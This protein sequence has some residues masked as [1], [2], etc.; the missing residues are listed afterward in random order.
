MSNLKKVLALALAFAMIMT[1]MVGAIPAYSDNDD[2]ATTGGDTALLDSAVTTLNDL[3]IMVGTKTDDGTYFN[4]TGTL[5]RAELSRLAYAVTHNGAVIASTWNAKNVT[6]FADISN[7]WAKGYI[8]YGYIMGYLSGKSTTKFDPNGIVTGYELGSVLVRLV[9]GYAASDIA[10]W[11]YDVEKLGR[12][13]GANLYSLGNNVEVDLATP[14][15]RQDAAVL[16]FN[17]MN[18]KTVTYLTTVNSYVASTETFL[19]Q[20]YSNSVGVTAQVIAVGT[21][22][23]NGTDGYITADYTYTANNATQHKY[24]KLPSAKATQAAI[25]ADPSILTLLGTE[26]KVNSTTDTSTVSGATIATSLT[27]TGKY[28]T[29]AVAKKNVNATINYAGNANK[30]YISFNGVDASG[31]AKVYSGT[32]EGAS[33][34]DIEY[35]SGF[36]AGAAATVDT[37][38][39]A[40]TAFK[41]NSNDLV[42]FKLEG[43]TIKAVVGAFSSKFAKVTS[44]AS[45]GKTVKFDDLSTAYVNSGATVKVGDYVLYVDLAQTTVVS[46]TVNNVYVTK[47]IAP[48]KYALTSYKSGAYYA[49]DFKLVGASNTNPSFAGLALGSSYMLF[50]DD[51]LVYKVENVADTATSITDYLVFTAAPATQKVVM[52]TAD[53]Y[54]AV[55]TAI[56]SDN[57]YKTV[58]IASLNGDAFTSTSVVPNVFP[59]TV[60]ADPMTGTPIPYR[61][62]VNEDGS[63]NLFTVRG[64]DKDLSVLSGAFNYTKAPVFFYI[65]G[66]NSAAFK[67]DS[68]PGAVTNVTV[69][70]VYGKSVDG[71]VQAF[72]GFVSGSGVPALALDKAGQK[73]EIVVSNGYSPL[74]DY[75]AGVYKTS[76]L[77]VSNAS[78]S[79]TLTFGKDTVVYAAKQLNAT[80]LQ[81]ST[82]NADAI[83]AKKVYR[84]TYSGAIGTQ[85]RS[86]EQIAVTEYNTV[87]IVTTSPVKFNADLLVPVQPLIADSTGKNPGDAGYV[88]TYGPSTSAFA[89][90]YKAGTTTFAINRGDFTK[91]DTA[92][93][94]AGVKF[95]AIGYTAGATINPDTVIQII[96]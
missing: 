2:F 77:D 27:D 44:V 12:T 79:K 40:D 95:Y 92:S 46:G 30:A 25:L 57:T 85:V 24:F 81:A 90:A 74:V 64:A 50:V 20:N 76:T 83:A 87:S 63:L 23:S 65:D 21:I 10:V 88:N 59:T 33:G 7:S 61:Y 26:V 70:S 75:V 22:G 58:A 80:D 36:S 53:K 11:P 3:N 4:P 84:V 72:V 52:L 47:V 89:V 37:A 19:E 54:Y 6:S 1:V 38:A 42:L 8:N 34:Y 93:F 15:T 78:G 32:I 14:I 45:D 60:P 48:A 68:D 13:F 29:V 31:A 71:F 41:G 35:I 67:M 91:A 66:A 16:I 49:G 56:L 73:S 39:Q 5:T 9:R 55:G 51:G 43:D 82:T 18:S 62:T 28:K 96:G 69:N 17:A 94:V 86:I